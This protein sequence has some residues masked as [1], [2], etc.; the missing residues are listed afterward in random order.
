MK[1]SVFLSS[2]RQ[3][4][5][6]LACASLLALPAALNA[7]DELE[8]Y[9]E[10]GGGYTL[11]SGDRPGF[12]KAFQL[13]KDGFGGIED[14]RYTK[15]INDATVLKIRGQ[16]MAG[17]GDYLL[18]LGLTKDEVG[19]L[20]FGYRQTRT[21]FD[22]T[23]GIWPINGLGFTLHNEDMHIDRGNLWFEAGLTRENLPSFVFR[24]DYLTREGTKDST[25][26]GDSGL[27]VSASAT[28]G[29]LPSFVKIDEKRH[30]LQ[31]TIAQRGEKNQWEVALR[32]EEGDQD[33][34]RYNRRRARETTADRYVTNREGQKYDLFQMRGAYAVD[35]TEQIKVTT[36]VSRTKMDTTLSGSRVVGSTFDAAYSST[37]PTRQV[38]DEGFFQLPG[39]DLGH[40]EMTQTVANIAV[41]YRPLEHLAVV[42][43][44]RFEK[45]ESETEV[46]FIETN[47]LPTINT[48]VLEDVLG[49]TDKDWKSYTGVVEFRYNGVKNVTFNLAGEWSKGD[50]DI[51]EL[52]VL[53]PGHT[54]QVI[55]I[56]R[57]TALDRAT[58]KYTFTTSWY[59]RPGMALSGQYYFKASQ[60]DYRHTRDNT[61]SASDKY[62]AFITNQDVETH[63]FNVRF[64]WRILPTLRSVTR[65][66]HMLSTINSQQTSLAFIETGERKQNILSQAFTWNPLPRWY[67]QAS[68]NFVNDRMETP[69]AYATGTASN[70][71]PVSKANY[72]SYGFST[73]YALDDASDVYATY[74]YYEARDSFFNNAPATVPFGY[75]TETQ[76][77]SVAWKRR[78]DRRTSVTVKYTYA[79]S[80]DPAFRG[81]A[82][83]EANMIQAKVQYRF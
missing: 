57:A 40:A 74:D 75:Q 38:R 20:K 64:S 70:L 43:S 19:Y 28:R 36:A 12:Q 47:F 53:E 18:D 82:D 41:L 32:Y 54:N 81:Q 46:E 68:A 35:V 2:V 5:L 65:Y 73:G 78:L 62:P 10:I 37:F 83:Y 29:V 60:N 13:R 30:V 21:Y 17:T 71:V 33:N 25:V 77:A 58:Q 49:K 80:E 27:P 44:L 66:D 34:A 14:L 15:Q 50:G 67:L 26:W 69:A 63:D 45:V 39:H 24:Y 61:V 7:A 55:S 23:G 59:F 76:S 48:P 4:A 56:D 16:A 72:N 52:R 3:P 51:G 6:L 31:G 22:G 79:K 9:I 11:Q 1:T 8:N 42:P